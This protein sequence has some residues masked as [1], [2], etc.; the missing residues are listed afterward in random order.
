VNDFEKRIRARL[1]NAIVIAEM[2]IRD[3]DRLGIRIA[4][5]G[6]TVEEVIDRALALV[7]LNIDSV[8]QDIANL[9]NRLVS[10]KEEIVP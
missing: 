4:A 9:N 5:N 2:A 7:P 1:E 6:P 8:N 10:L 3:G